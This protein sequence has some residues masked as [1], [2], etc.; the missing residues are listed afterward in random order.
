M[1]RFASGARRRPG[2]G[3]GRPPRAEAG[4]APLPGGRRRRCAILRPGF[5]ARRVRLI[6]ERRLE[7]IILAAFT[8]FLVIHAVSFRYTVD[9]AFISPPLRAE[10]GRG[11]VS[12]LMRASGSR[13]TR[14]SSG[15]RS[16]RARWSSAEPVA[17]ARVAGILAGLL[18]LWGVFSLA[19]RHLRERSILLLVLLGL[20]ANGAFALWCGA[21]LETSLFAFLLFAGV[22]AAVREEGSDTFLLASLF[23]ALAL[24]TRLEGACY[25]ALLIDRASPPNSAAA[26]SPGVAL[27][28]WSWGTRLEDRVLRRLS[29]HLLRENGGWRGR[30]GP[31]PAATSADSADGRPSPLRLFFGGIRDGND[32]LAVL[33]LP[34]YV[35]WAGATSTVLSF[36]APAVPLL[37]LRRRPRSPRRRARSRAPGA[38]TAGSRSFALPRES[39]WG[40]GLPLREDR[41]GRASLEGDRSGSPSMRIRARSR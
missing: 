2:I 23:L 7:L 29:E 25:A 18:L 35:V 31:S 27:F 3:I 12:S 11:T 33:A 39:W 40:G 6:R 13:G 32:R 9:D 8:A 20:V 4:S 1:L 19:R 41:T 10:L 22:A 38:R 5:T 37:V 24:L 30:A 17:F 34:A 21:G 28:S 14:T 36:V 15:P 16:S 26:D